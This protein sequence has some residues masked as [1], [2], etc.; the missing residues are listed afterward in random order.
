VIDP[1]A[2]EALFGNTSISTHLYRILQGTLRDDHEQL[3]S[4]CNIRQFETAKSI[5]HRIKGA[6]RY[7]K[8]PMYEYY[9][10]ALEEDIISNKPIEDTLIALDKACDLLY[11][12]IEEL[13]A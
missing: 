12:T 2:T 5:I 6:L 11:T 10:L 7:C 13:L 1:E 4:D 8:A 3:L 9:L